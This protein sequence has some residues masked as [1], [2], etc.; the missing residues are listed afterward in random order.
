MT[1]YLYIL[2]DGKLG[3]GRLQPSPLELDAIE[4]GVLTIVLFENDNVY[5]IDSEGNRLDIG[6]VDA[7]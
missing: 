7:I 3:T 2:E 1:I 5:E 4:N 6:G